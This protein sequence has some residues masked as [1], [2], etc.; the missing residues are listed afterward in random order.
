MGNDKSII[1]LGGACGIIGIMTFLGIAVILERFYWQK[2]P[3]ETTEDV[4]RLFASTPHSQV[5]MGGHLLVGFAAILFLVAFLALMKIFESEK[6]APSARIGG[7]LGVIACPIMVIQMLIQGTVMVRL[8]RMFVDATDDAQ[9]QSVV[10]LYRGLRSFDIGIDLAFDSFF[11]MAWI[12]LSLAMLKNRH[13]GKI[14]G[15]TGLALFA[16]TTCLNIGAAPN[17]PN[18]EMA[19]LASLWVLAVYIQMMRSAKSI[20]IKPELN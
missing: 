9:R 19:P 5:A 15:V 6:P 10:I 16:I 3:A 11:F 8:G 14:F 2:I 18:F 17:P 7:I 13:F 4:L 20:S 12:L 1:R